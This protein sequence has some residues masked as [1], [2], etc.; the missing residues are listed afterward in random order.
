MINPKHRRVTPDQWRYWG[1]AAALLALLFAARLVVFRQP[2]QAEAYFWRV[3]AAAQATPTTNLPWV[4][5]ESP[6]P[7][8]AISMLR[9]NITVSRKYTNLQTGQQATLLL[10]QC[11]DARA[12]LGHYPPKCY[13]ANGYRQTSGAPRDWQVDGLAI[14]GMVYAFSFARP[15]EISSLVIYDFMILPDGHTCRDMEGVYA[16]ARD[17]QKRRLGAA[18]LQVLLDS[19]VPEEQRDATFLAL[20]G[21]HRHTIDAILAGA[22]P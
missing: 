10:V 16:M 17:P 21:A 12:L 18:Q 19:S 3:A 14:Q 20:I 2:P 9:P 22:V 4:S 6:V 8:A 5:L 15:D 1:L 7:P 11:R 13:V